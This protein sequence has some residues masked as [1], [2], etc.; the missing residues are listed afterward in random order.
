MTLRCTVRLHHWRDWLTIGTSTLA[1][2]C[3]GAVTLTYQVRIC[4][5][6]GHVVA[7][8]RVEDTRVDQPALPAVRRWWRGLKRRARVRRQRPEPCLISIERGENI[9]QWAE[10]VMREVVT[11]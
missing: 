11:S 6:C 3:G 1:A 2:E 8:V 7:R 5:E 10:R 4:A 9:G